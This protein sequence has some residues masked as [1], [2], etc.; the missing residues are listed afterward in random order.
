MLQRALELLATVQ[1]RVFAGLA[2]LAALAAFLAPVEGWTFELPLAIAAAATLALWLL[3]EFQS[4]VV[5]HPHDVEL[6]KTVLQ[7]IGADERALLRTQDFL[8]DFKLK[9]FAGVRRI[10]TSWEGPEFEFLDAALQRRWARTFGV[11]VTFRDEMARRTAPRRGALDWQTVRT[12]RELAAGDE[13]SDQA[14]DDAKVLND[15]ATQL[16]AELDAFIPYAKRRL[17]L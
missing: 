17:G 15:T 4:A 5:R 12:G 9:E 14:R 11:M 8:D 7:L 3:A 1:A 10:S 16:T 6:M 2:M 13:I